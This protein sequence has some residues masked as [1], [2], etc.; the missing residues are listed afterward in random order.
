MDRSITIGKRPFRGHGIWNRITRSFGQKGAG[1]SL[2]LSFLYFT[3]ASKKEIMA[4]NYIERQQEQYEARKAA[5][6]QAQ[7]YGKKKTGTTHQVR[8]GQRLTRYLPVQTDGKEEFFVAGGAEG[9]GKSNR[10]SIFSSGLP[11]RFL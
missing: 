11:G 5:W 8:T 6:K 10:R 9:I 7:K 1:D 3:F 2:H 4:D